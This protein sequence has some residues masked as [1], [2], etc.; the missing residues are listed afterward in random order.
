MSSRDDVPYIIVERDSGS[1]VGSFVLGALLGA[2]AALLLAPRSGRETQ[3][4]I[5]ERARELRE[6]AEDRLKEASSHLEARLEDARDGVEHRLDR[7]R[8]AVDSGKQAANEARHELE[9]KLERSKAAYRAGIEA[10]RAAAASSDGE[11]SDTAAS[12]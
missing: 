5:R 8:D 2:G 11:E 3:D 9:D 10:A 12:D 4:E 1:G 7:V 6:A